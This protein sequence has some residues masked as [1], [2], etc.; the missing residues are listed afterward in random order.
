[1]VPGS[2][3]RLHVRAIPADTYLEEYS[4]DRTR[5]PGRTV[6][7]YIHWIHGDERFKDQ[8]LEEYL[9]GI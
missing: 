8:T 4:F 3:L 5:T 1:M 9:K 6:K 2:E 7:N